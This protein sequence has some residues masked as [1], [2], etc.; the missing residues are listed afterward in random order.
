MRFNEKLKIFCLYLAC[1][2]F[3]ETVALLKGI[4]G[5]IYGLSMAAIG[6]TGGFIIKGY[7]KD[8]HKKKV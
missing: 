1:I 8:S 3:L 5:T 2:T 6:T 7:L 4:D